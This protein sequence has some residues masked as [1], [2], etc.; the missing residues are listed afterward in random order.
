MRGDIPDR[1]TGGAKLVNGAIGCVL[2]E[3]RLDRSGPD[4]AIEGNGS[5]VVSSNLAAGR[6]TLDDK[7]FTETNGLALAD[8]AHSKVPENRK[9]RHN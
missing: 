6:E 1:A 8:E 7:R 2:T 3:N 4:V 9:R 5:V